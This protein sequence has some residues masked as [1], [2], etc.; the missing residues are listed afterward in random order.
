MFY[1][2]VSFIPVKR[3]MY[4]MITT[5]VE[6]GLFDDTVFRLLVGHFFLCLCIV[7]EDGSTVRT[8][9]THIIVSVAALSIL[10]IKNYF[11]DAI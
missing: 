8:F 2:T 10:S 7:A 4:L 3:E 1:K 5:A 9:V 6:T 11:K